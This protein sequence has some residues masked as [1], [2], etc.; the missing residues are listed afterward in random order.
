MTSTAN[1]PD[2]SDL[3]APW[4]GW[5]DSWSSFQHEVNELT[6]IYANERFVWRGH[7]NARWG[8]RSS[9][10]RVLT[11]QLNRPPTED[12]LVAAEKRLLKLARIEW[13]LDGTP[14]LQLFAQMQHVGVPTRLLDVTFNPLIAAWFA[15]ARDRS[16]DEEPARLLVFTDSNRPLQLHTGWNTNT[17]RWHRLP[18]EATR[19]RVDW[20]TGLGRKIWRPPA[21]HNRI[22]AQNAAFILDGSPIDALESDRPRPNGRSM[23]AAAELRRYASVP[24]RLAHV[25]EDRLPKKAPVF[26]YR[27]T[28]A[29]KNEIREQLEERFGYRFATVYADIEGMAEYLKRW[30]ETISGTT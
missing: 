28:P 4:E 27:I 25:G 24:M 5:I 3:F 8:L 15:V 20:G 11:A 6:S 23:W 18:D 22:P 13:R 7:A 30:P 26:T 17:P 29:A 12:D 10:D 9:L 19:R 2:A 16:N 1:D 21:L 14:A